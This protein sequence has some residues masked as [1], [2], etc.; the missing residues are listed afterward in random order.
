[1]TP[2]LITLTF[3][4]S[5]LLTRHFSRPDTVLYIV[6]APNARSLHT[7]PI[8]VSG[9]VAILVAVT[10]AIL[11]TCWYVSHLEHILWMCVGGAAIAIISFVDDCR[12]IPAPFR[13]TVHFLAACLLL[14]QNEFWI[15]QGVLPGLSWDLSPFLQVILS[16]LFIVWMINLYNFMDGM[17][18]F[19]GG[20]AVFGFGSLAI[21]GGLAGQWLFMAMNLVIVSAAAGFLVFNF[22]PAKIF[23]GDAGASTLGFLAATFSLWGHHIEIFPL[24]SALLIFSPFIVDA[25]VTLLRRTLNGEKVWVAHKS[26]YYQRLVQLGWGHKRTV[27]W[28]YLLMAGCSL[29]AILAIFAPVWI[30][31]S[32]LIGWGIGY[33]Y[34]MHWVSWLEQRARL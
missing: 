34:L 24:W 8:P 32:L 16:F 19:A 11:L 7:R 13:L 20:M 26:H 18:G 28:E 33:G 4:V 1:M 17:D 5:A 22:P 2:T 29:S 10:L 9:G 21:L 25:T 30:Q 6:H 27:L 31:W 23:M 3:V 14:C 12:H 15:V